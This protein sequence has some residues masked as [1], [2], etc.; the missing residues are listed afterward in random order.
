MDRQADVPELVQYRNNVVGIAYLGF[1]LLWIWNIPHGLKHLTNWCRAG[2]ACFPFGEDRTSLCWA[3]WPQT[4]RS[5]CLCICLPSAG[6]KG[7]PHRTCPS[8][9]FGGTI[10]KATEVW[11]VG[12][13]PWERG[14]LREGLEVSQSG[15]TSCLLSTSGRIHQ[16]PSSWFMIDRPA[17]DAFPGVVW[18]N[19]S[20]QMIN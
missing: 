17:D 10:W 5:A 2:D 16:P 7:M 18:W 12:N 9:C 6:N 19:A 13:I 1:V 8:V 4:L 3:G 14:S 11:G 15:P 20:P